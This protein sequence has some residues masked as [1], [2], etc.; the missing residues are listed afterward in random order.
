[1][2]FK[3]KVTSIT[4][5]SLFLT[6]CNVEEAGNSSVAGSC[7]SQNSPYGE[8]TPPPSAVPS[9]TTGDLVNSEAA[10]LL[11]GDR[12]RPVKYEPDDDKT[13]VFIGQDNRGVFDYLAAGMAKPAGYSH[14]IAF[15]R[16]GEDGE[17]QI[18]GLWEETASDWGA[19][20]VCLECAILYDQN[21][22]WS[23]SV[24]HLSIWFAQSNLAQL[25][26]SGGGDALIRELAEFMNQYD[27][28]PFFLRPGYEFDF[29]YMG[30]GITAE[31][32]RAAYRRIIDVL[33]DNQVDNFTSVF[34]AAVIDGVGGNTARYEDWV[35]YYPGN[36][37]VDWIGYSLFSNSNISD[38]SAGVRFAEDVNKPLFLSEATPRGF[39][40]TEDNH[41]TVWNN[42]L[43]NMFSH[44]ED[45]D[46][47][48]QVKALAYINTSWDCQ[49]EWAGDG[50]GDTR[51]ENSDSLA[52]IWNAKLGVDSV[53]YIMENDN[54]YSEIN[55]TPAQ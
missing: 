13:L 1:M 45:N 53:P 2:D 9:F 47:A 49:R 25:F 10:E 52:A 28:I 32:Y 14:Y 39:Q 18:P 3:T 22:D 40:I 35:A 41:E 23:D 30:N 15:D 48:E 44:T 24:V 21:I 29:Q 33:R 51:I 4:L 55:F 8:A 36:D 6:A 19:G 34:S 46:L 16:P 37:Y 5:L 20:P 50:W 26:G 7:P 11:T 31:Q 42:Y 17:R 43:A 54:V 12:S 38:T 27:H